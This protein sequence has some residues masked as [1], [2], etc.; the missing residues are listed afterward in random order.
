MIPSGVF[1]AQPYVGT[2]SLHR[3]GIDFFHFCHRLNNLI[4][5]AFNV[6]MHDNGTKLPFHHFRGT[7]YRHLAETKMVCYCYCCFCCFFSQS[8]IILS[9][10]FYLYPSI[11]YQYLSYK[12]SPTG[13]STPLNGQS[14]ESR[15]GTS[16]CEAAGQTTAPPSCLH[17]KSLGL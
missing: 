8:F 2:H 1:S 5:S 16:C 15:P 10:H 14:Q 4:N 6:Y 7:D 3:Q 17:F 13:D 11:I 9:L 12:G